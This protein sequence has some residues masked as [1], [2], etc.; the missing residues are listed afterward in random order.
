MAT[1]QITDNGSS[2]TIDCDGQSNTYEKKG[3]RFFDEGLRLSIYTPQGITN[4]NTTNVFPFSNGLFIIDLSVDLVVGSSAI[5]G[6]ELRN[7]LAPIFFT[8]C[9]SGGGGQVNSQGFIDYNNTLPAINLV[10]DTWTIIPNNGAGAFTNKTYAPL[11][12]TELMNV[13]TGAIDP[14]KLVKGDALFIRNDYTINPNTNNALLEFRYGLGGGGNEYTLR[15]TK[16]R[17]DNGSGIDYRYSLTTDYIYMGDDNTKDNPITLQ[18]KL[19]TNGTL[20]NAGS[21]IQVVKRKV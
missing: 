6:A 5:T 12:I 17:L 1:Y 19:S 18:V 13:V 16:G 9:N 10:A 8:D 3:F 20:S 11:G 21:V 4:I 15:T 7:E 2:V 14:T